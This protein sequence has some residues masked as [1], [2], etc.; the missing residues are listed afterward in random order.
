MPNVEFGNQARDNILRYLID[1][2]TGC[3]FEVEKIENIVT[4]KLISKAG[5][6]LDSF[7]LTLPEDDSD[8]LVSVELDYENSQMIF[9]TTHNVITC[10]ISDIV[11]KINN[12]LSILPNKQDTLTSCD[13]YDITKTQTLIQE[14]GVLKWVEL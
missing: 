2:D 3:A 4:I 1:N 6:V 9:T 7:Q 10:D 14:N 5:K 8:A 11:G 12:I 13:G